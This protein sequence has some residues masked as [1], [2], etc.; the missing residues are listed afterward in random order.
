MSGN[1][2]LSAL[3]LLQFRSATDGGRR[4]TRLEDEVVALFDQFREPLLRY[5]SSFGLTLPDRED[6]VQEAFLALFRHLQSGKS[7]EHIRGWLFRVA[8]NVGLKRRMGIRR[9]FESDFED[10]LVEPGLGPED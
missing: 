8:H 4:D 2:A 1:G 6:V 7:R 10:S 5:L 9:D 3:S